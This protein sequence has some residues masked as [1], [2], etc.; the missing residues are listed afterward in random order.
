M[1]RGVKNI[2]FSFEGAA[3]SAH[4]VMLFDQQDFKTL[5]DQQIATYQSAYAGADD[6]GVV[7][8]FRAVSKPQTPENAFHSLYSII[9]R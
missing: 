3:V 8:G 5:T 7:G 9:I 1:A 4:H 2:S 6:D